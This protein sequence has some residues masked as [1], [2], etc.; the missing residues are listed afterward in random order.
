MIRSVRR[1]LEGGNVRCRAPPAYACA[2]LCRYL[3]EVCV[4][5][6]SSD[7]KVLRKFGVHEELMPVVHETIEGTRTCTLR[8]AYLLRNCLCASALVL[9]SVFFCN[10]F[11][12]FL[13]CYAC[14]VLFCVLLFYFMHASV[15]IASSEA[16]TPLP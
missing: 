13:F 2:A 6:F 5:C 4:C 7:I 1:T 10:L 14:S 12:S 11:I 8:Y 9:L 15:Y 16:L 3:P